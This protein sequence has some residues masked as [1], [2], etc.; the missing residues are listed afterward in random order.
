M[1]FSASYLFDYS[2]IKDKARFTVFNLFD[3]INVW[4]RYFRVTNGKL[5]PVDVYMIG[6]T[7]TLFAEIN[8]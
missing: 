2:W 8:F 1:D 5:N 3:N 4:H 7:P 6:F